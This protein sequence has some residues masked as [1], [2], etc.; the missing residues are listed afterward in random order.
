MQNKIAE[1]TDDIP[2]LLVT[3]TPYEIYTTADRLVLGSQSNSDS[4]VK[5]KLYYMNY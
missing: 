1:A 4:K 5:V 2:A 3:V